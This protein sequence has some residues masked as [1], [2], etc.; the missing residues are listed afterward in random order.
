MLEEQI[1][2]CGAPVLAGLKTAAL[3]N[4]RFR[5][6]EEE[7]ERLACLN[8]TLNRRDIYLRVLRHRAGA[9]QIYLYRRSRLEN[10][11][12]RRG[13]KGF[14]KKYGYNADD[15]DSAIVHL[16]ERLEEVGEFPHEIGLF[17]GYP[18]AD[19]IG[20]IENRGMNYRCVG[21]WKVYHNEQETRKV[22]EQFEKCVEIYRRIYREGRSLLQLVA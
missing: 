2:E 4:Y 1:I 17:L 12:G 22:F 16:E 13:V 14:M 11:L 15:P 10:D 3:F 6:E 8:E 19:V 9:S 20:F 7:R 5:S 18:L 21:F